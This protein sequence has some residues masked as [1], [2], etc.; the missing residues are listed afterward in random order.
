M[1]LAAGVCFAADAPPQAEIS[2][3]QIQAKIYLPDVKTGFYRGTRFDWSGVV[4]GLVYKG[5]DYYGRWFQR[6]DP[7]VRD[8]ADQS[9]E[10]VASPCSA[11]TGP[12]DEFLT[13]GRGLGWNDAKPGG[14]F[15]KIGVGVLRKDNA[16]YDHY[17]LYEIVDAG[18]WA[19]RKGR[20]FVEFT[21]EVADPSL[22]YGYTYRKTMR[23][24]AGKPE[25][26]LE[27]SLKNTGSKAIQSS[28]YN[29]N[30]LVLDQ[31]VTG[32]DFTITV[33]Y[34][35]KSSRPPQ[36][37][38]IRGN[39][40][41]YLKTLAPQEIATTPVSGFGDSPKDHEVRIENS[42]LGV[43]VKFNGDRPLANASLWSIRSVVSIEP[44]VAIS[45]EPGAEFTWKATYEYYTLPAKGN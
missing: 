16:N 1:A 45:I 18:K 32:P 38:E 13:N 5:H 11:I 6:M 34:Q 37:A 30:F 20:D 41:V 23:L 9:T 4:G 2:N 15:I 7:N 12:V 44:F 25:M 33:P 31:Q 28:V 26:V 10:I 24:T 19:V 35:I 36:F 43:G 39:Q 14:T 29:H 22:G 8:Y 17:K 27:H 3:G 42:K 40:I 21:Q